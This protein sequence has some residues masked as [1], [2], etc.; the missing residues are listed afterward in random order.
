MQTSMKRGILSDPFQCKPEMTF[1]KVIFLFHMI[2]LRVHYER[3]Y[4]KSAVLLANDH[5]SDQKKCYKWF[6]YKF[7]LCI[8]SR[9]ND[10]YIGMPENVASRRILIKMAAASV[11]HRI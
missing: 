11:F 7:S 6:S 10:S 3:V 1:F 9:K 5:Q 8:S 2:Y 4:I